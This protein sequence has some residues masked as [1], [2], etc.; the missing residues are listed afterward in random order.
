[1]G[2]GGYFFRKQLEAVERGVSLAEV[3]THHGHRVNAYGKSLCP[4]HED[5]NP[6]LQLYDDGYYCFA[7]GAHGDGVDLEYRLGSYEQMWEAMVALSVR[8]GVDLPPKP[9]RRIKDLS[10][11]TALH[12]AAD[13]L[14]AVRERYARL[15]FR[16]CVE[17]QIEATYTDEDE[18]EKAA[19]MVAAYGQWRNNE[20]VI[21][22]GRVMVERIL[23]RRRKKEPEKE[24][25]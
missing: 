22:R 9:D 2:D 7:C 23:Q 17:P 11:H 24:S 5:G 6:S 12:R 14:P 19:A 15:T 13:D 20:A 3:L 1:M 10:D 4:F 25:A 16:V 21:A 18:E 8:H